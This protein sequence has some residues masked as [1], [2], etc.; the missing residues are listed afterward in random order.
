MY[1]VQRFT[2]LL[3][4]DSHSCCIEIHRVVAQRYTEVLHRVVAQ[5]F[6]ELLHGDSQ[7]GFTEIHRGFARRCTELLHRGS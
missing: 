6:T 4:G 1:V 5:R 3:Y 2:E 7:S